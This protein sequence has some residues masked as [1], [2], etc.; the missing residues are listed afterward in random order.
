MKKLFFLIFLV[1]LGCENKEKSTMDRSPCY[2]IINDPE[3][4]PLKIGDRVPNV[5]GVTNQGK[6]FNL[7]QLKGDYS[8]I[9]FKRGE[10]GV[11][12]NGEI[13]ESL[14]STALTMNKIDLLI[15]SDLKMIDLFDID[16]SEKSNRRNI[17]LVVNNDG[18]L[19]GVYYN[20]CDA[21]IADIARKFE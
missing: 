4:I 3:L 1:F 5:S 10:V 19:E 21:D 13:D 18:L 11:L 8:F 6:S 2:K 17:L 15:T 9:L 14:F 16:I 7:K 20:L 12:L